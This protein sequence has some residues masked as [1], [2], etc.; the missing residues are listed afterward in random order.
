MVQWRGEKQL[1]GMKLACFM[2][3]GI[4]SQSAGLLV[5]HIPLY[6]VLCTLITYA[7]SRAALLSD[8]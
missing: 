3:W 2:T 7:Y 5:S 8:K 1:G 4:F 6:S